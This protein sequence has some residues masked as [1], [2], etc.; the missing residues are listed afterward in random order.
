MI[1][2]RLKRATSPSSELE[3]LQMISEPDTRR[4]TRKNIGSPRGLDCEIPHW[5]GR[6][7]ETFL[8]RVGKPLP[9]VLKL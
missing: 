2:N 6:G 5:L 3:L 8:I 4:C 1:H 9:S 7:N